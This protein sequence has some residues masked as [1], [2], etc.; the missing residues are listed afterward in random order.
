MNTVKDNIRNFVET[1]MTQL[2]LY[3]VHSVFRIANA[4]LQWGVG[5]NAS[6]LV[7]CDKS[8]QKQ[9]FYFKST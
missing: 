7:F 4:I 3:G 1:Q 5:K 9:T 2:Y 6:H 8:L